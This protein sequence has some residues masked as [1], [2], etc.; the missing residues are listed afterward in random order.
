MK[1]KA[2]QII[3]LV[4]IALAV[5]PWSK[6]D[7]SAPKLP[8]DRVVA[9]Y[10]SCNQPVAEASVMAGI[11]VQAI[12]KAGKWRQYDKDKIP[13]AMK[14]S[15]DP[16]VASLGIP[17]VCLFRGGSVVASAKFPSSDAEL[18]AYIQKNGGF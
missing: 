4:I 7:F 18:S 9:I 2:N 5:V 16:A 17:C 15:L 1:L 14:P 11:T 10:E 8:I 12:D 3:G 13:Q 6:I